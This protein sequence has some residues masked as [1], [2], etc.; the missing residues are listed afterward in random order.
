MS[1]KKSEVRYWNLLAKV[2]IKGLDFFKHQKKMEG[3]NIVK[4]VVSVTIQR[5]YYINQYTYRSFENVFT[6]VN[7]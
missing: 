7:K 2:N 1:G 3:I 6:S 5:S 4:D